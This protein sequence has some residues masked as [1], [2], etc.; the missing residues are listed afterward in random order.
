MAQYTFAKAEDNAASFAGADLSGSAIAQ[1]WRN[2]EGSGAGRASINAISLR[3]RSN[4]PRH[5]DQRGALLTGKKGALYKGWT[6]TG[7][8]N[9]G[10]GLPLTPVYLG[11]LAGTGVVGSIRAGTRAYRLARSHLAII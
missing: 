10:S 5:G 6:V 11:S 9:V 7:Q 1:D 4:T 3:P 2:L 8:L